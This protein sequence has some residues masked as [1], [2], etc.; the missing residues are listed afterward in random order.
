M[1]CLSWQGSEPGLYGGSTSNLHQGM[2]SFSRALGATWD[3][4][5]VNELIANFRCGFCARYLS[6]TSGSPSLIMRCTIIKLLKTMVH[7]ESRS[8]FVRALKISATPASPAWVATSICST[9]L[10]FGAAS[11][12]WVLAGNSYGP[13]R[14]V[15]RMRTTEGRAQPYLD[16]GAALDALLE[17]ACHISLYESLSRNALAEGL[18]LAG[19]DA[20]WRRV[21]ASCRWSFAMSI[22]AWRY[23]EIIGETSLSIEK[24]LSRRRRAGRQV[25]N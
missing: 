22:A 5:S 3:V 15:M 16:L 24:K 4:P 7:V 25:V 9:Y 19:V 11:Y 12:T 21:L 6:V 20:R 2:T 18:L 17:G 23:M 13:L 8:R 14:S 1:A 10:D